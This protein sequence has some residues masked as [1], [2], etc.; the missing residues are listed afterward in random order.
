MGAKYVSTLGRFHGPHVTKTEQFG[1]LWS[2]MDSPKG[3]AAVQENYDLSDQYCTLVQLFLLDQS[4]LSS[5][6]NRL[7][8][9][10][11]RCEGAPESPSALSGDN[12]DV[13]TTSTCCTGFVEESRQRFRDCVKALE[14]L[15]HQR[16]MLLQ[17]MEQKEA[18]LSRM[19]N[20]ITECCPANPLNGSTSHFSIGKYMQRDDDVHSVTSENEIQDQ[21]VYSSN[22]SCREGEESIAHSVL[23]HDINL[24]RQKT[25]LV[26]DNDSETVSSNTQGS[27]VGEEEGWN[28][29]HRKDNDQPVVQKQ[30][31]PKAPRRWYSFLE[32][33][34]ES[35]PEC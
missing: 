2:I 4:H 9:D 25:S 27:M 22:D 1:R 30:A 32:L 16:E 29:S 7:L 35:F 34:P 3:V 14:A 6:R 26:T 11:D 12:S 21:S 24:S 33:L 5:Y 28:C 20:T 15:I 19:D 17:L 18:L 10:I 8:E 23:R 13:S 31:V